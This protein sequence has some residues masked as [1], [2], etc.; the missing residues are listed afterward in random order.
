MNKRINLTK[1]D[2]CY[3]KELRESCYDI[4][5]LVN[6]KSTTVETM[7]QFVDTVIEPARIEAEAKARFRK[8]L[9]ECQTKEEIQN[10][11]SQ[12]VIH[13]MYYMP[14]RKAVK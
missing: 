13:G 9:Q 11:C 3:S 2:G 10:L 6:D 4:K 14:K 7:K 1:I 5:L 8:N 12:A